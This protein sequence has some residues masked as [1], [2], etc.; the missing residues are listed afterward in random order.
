[1]ARG[2]AAH[3]KTKLLRWFTSQSAQFAAAA[4]QARANTRRI[5][6]RERGTTIGR[7]LFPFD[8]S[9]ARL[10]ERFFAKVSP[11][12]VAEPRL[13]QLNRERA[14]QL[15]LDPERLSRADALEVFAGNRVPSGA[16]PIATAY[17]GFQFGSWVPQLGDGRAVLLG[18]VI[19]TDGVRRDIQLKGSGRTPFSRG[20]DGRA[21][22]GPVLRE[23]VVS[24][25]MAALGIPTTRA[26]AAVTTGENI[27]RETALPGA[28]LTRVAQSHIRVGT[29]QFFASRR[30]V[31]G[32]RALTEHVIERHYPEA[33]EGENPAL[34]MLGAVVS[35]QAALIARWQLVGFIHGVMN[36]DNTSIAGETIDYG[37][38]AF[39][40]RY[41]PDTVFSSIDHM[42]RYAY[43]NQ[44]SIA[45]WNLRG[46]AN[47]L[48]PVIADDPE[49]AVEPATDVLQTFPDRFRAFYREGMRRK[50]GLSE[51]QEG[52]DEL[53]HDLLSRMADHGAD[54]TLTFR[55]LSALGDEP[56]SDDSRVSSLFREP[57]AFDEWA[58]RWR[59]RISI[60]AI[61]FA[62]GQQ[63]M[64]SVNPAFIPRNHLIEQV[65]QSAVRE[66]DY[67]PFETLL[68][69]LL[70]PYEDQPDHVDYQAPPRPDEVVHQTFCGT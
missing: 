67:T 47:T 10:P 38:C 35:R 63:E 2:H 48:L 31:E 11:P 52:D 41:H 21:G 43:G 18:E 34:A 36:T 3:P 68:E 50:L 65:I 66:N 55:R 20:G 46:L 4:N 64:R 53:A 39:M 6:P 45:F 5:A 13:I 57:L 59:R 7:L 70:K 60:D 29:F 69:V 17:A 9:Y 25:A 19:G 16:E 40:D 12:P 54:F 26:L 51:W 30:D 58:M 56:S 62:E 24:E 15:G 1:M 49:A 14:L 28:V 44:P 32:I 61:P 23:Y 33:A 22:V 8:N 27:F 42:G 37:P